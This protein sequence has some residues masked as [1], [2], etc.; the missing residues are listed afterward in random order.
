[1]H[2]LWWPHQ[3]KTQIASDIQQAPPNKTEGIN[4]AAPNL[5]S[6]PFSLSSSMNHDA[7][8][9][10]NHLDIS[11]HDRINKSP[12]IKNVSQ[13]KYGARSRYFFKAS[14]ITKENRG[15]LYEDEGSR[16]PSLPDQTC[17]L[18]R[19]ASSVCWPTHTLKW[20]S[21]SCLLTGSHTKILTIKYEL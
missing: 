15:S 3:K 5:Q 6:F 4:P 7:K 9:M 17:S 20:R 14:C 13:H 18:A 11:F 21:S 8:Q 10:R 12:S 16:R 1:M 19:V 2:N